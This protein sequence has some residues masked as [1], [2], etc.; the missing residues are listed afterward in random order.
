MTFAPIVELLRRMQV[1]D[2]CNEPWLLYTLA[3]IKT[4][5]CG[6]VQ[7]SAEGGGEEWSRHARATVDPDGEKFML[8]RELFIMMMRIH[9]QRK[10][11]H[12]RR[13]RS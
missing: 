6:D 12:D 1:E 11:A 3:L 8:P 5:V 10:S 4:M 7:G 2:D 13:P 9:W